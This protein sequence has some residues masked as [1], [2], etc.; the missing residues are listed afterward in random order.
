MAEPV[1]KRVLL[2][3]SGEALQGSAPGGVDFGV[4]GGYADELAAAAAEGVQIGLVVGGGT[5]SAA[6]RGWRARPTGPRATT[7]ACWPR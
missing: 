1:Y 4:V 6:R 7:W 2:K 5:S 3:M